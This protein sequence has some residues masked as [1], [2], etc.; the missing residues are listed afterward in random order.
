MSPRKKEN[1]EKKRHNRQENLLTIK[2]ERVCS[3]SNKQILYN[4]SVIPR[5]S[6]LL[7]SHTHRRKVYNFKWYKKLQQQLRIWHNLIFFYSSSF[8]CSSVPIFMY[9]LR[10]VSLNTKQNREL[11]S[12]PACIVTDW[13]WDECDGRCKRGCCRCWVQELFRIPWII[14]GLKDVKRNHHNNNSSACLNVSLKTSTREMAES[15]KLIL[16]TSIYT[17]RYQFGENVVIAV[18][19]QGWNSVNYE[20]CYGGFACDNLK[21]YQRSLRLLF[22]CYGNRKH[23]ISKYIIH[24]ERKENVNSISDILKLSGLNSF[25][26]LCDFNRSFPARRRNVM[27]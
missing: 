21:R 6:N 16:F 4:F 27:K 15:E 23:N 8:S 11:P 19:Q 10:L 24:E 22:F 1:E 12:T 14:R 3:K 5:I 20:N 18:L 17:F 26:F 9:A 2:L 7:H 25:P 13:V